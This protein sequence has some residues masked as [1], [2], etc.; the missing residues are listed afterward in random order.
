MTDSPVSSLLSG[1]DDISAERKIKTEDHKDG[2]RLTI[3]I[4]YL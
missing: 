1:K 2:D 3:I 4:L